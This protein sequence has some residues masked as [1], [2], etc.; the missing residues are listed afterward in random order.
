MAKK[1]QSRESRLIIANYSGGVCPDCYW[2]IGKFVVDGGSCRNCDHVF[3][4]PP[5]DKVDMTLTLRIKYK[6]RGV[7]ISDLKTA[8]TQMVTEAI[9]NGRLTGETDA[10][11]L[12]YEYSITTGR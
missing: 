2:K 9:S 10:V 12:N 1:K 8:L 3:C 11:V 5:A 7:T 4:L 6:P